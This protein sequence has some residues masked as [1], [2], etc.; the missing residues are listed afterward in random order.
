MTKRSPWQQIDSTYVYEGPWI[1]FR[2]Y[3]VI[4]PD[5]K[6]GIYD[7]VEKKHF[8]TVVPTENDRFYL[9]QQYRYPIHEV[10]LEFPQGGL[11]ENETPEEAVRRELQEETGIIDPTLTHLGFLWLSTGQMSQ[12]Y[13]VFLAENFERKAQQLE[14]SEKDLQ[15]ISITAAE[16]KEQISENKIKDSTTVA[17]FSLYLLHH[18]K[19]KPV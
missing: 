12:G 11:M 4:K 6:P 14:D 5:G 9:V 10:T 13:T 7:V 18:T 1:K 3:N 19:H 17:A 15:V 2:H 16:L 8:V